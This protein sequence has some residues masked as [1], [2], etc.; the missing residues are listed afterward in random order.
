MQVTSN[1]KVEVRYEISG[2]HEG[3]N[4]DDSLLG[5][6]AVLPRLSTQTFQR[7]AMPPSSGR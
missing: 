2:F 4:E 7:C 1:R 5:Y 3:E 6:K